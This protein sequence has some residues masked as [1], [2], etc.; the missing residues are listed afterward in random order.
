MS[1]TSTTPEGHVT[2]AEMRYGEKGRIAS[3]ASH[4][5]GGAE[6]DESLAARL[7][8]LG[9]MEGAEIEALHRSPFGGDPMSV[10]V[11][12]TII[13]LRRADAGTI[14]IERLNGN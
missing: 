10:K 12:R 8:E 13:A 14:I 2:L 11:D 4:A 5:A 7:L 1:D 9:I 6:N 3:I